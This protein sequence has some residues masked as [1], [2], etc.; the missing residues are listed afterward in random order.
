MIIHAVAKRPHLR[1]ML[2]ALA[3]V[4]LTFLNFGHVSVSASGDI[5]VTPDSWCGSPLAPEGTPHSP[6]HA[7]RADGAAL[8]PPPAAIEPIVFIV[9][10]L[11]YV[12]PIAAIEVPLHSRPAQPRGPPTL[13]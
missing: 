4:A 6:C 10:D 12:A 9:T 5:Q 3:V 1:E 8:P 7:C 11:A 13:V 2:L